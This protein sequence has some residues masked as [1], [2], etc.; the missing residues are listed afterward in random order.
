[1]SAKEL[2]N[3]TTV[4]TLVDQRK[5]HAKGISNGSCPL[6]STSI[7]TD[8]DSLPIVGNVVLDVLAQKMAA[9]K[10]VNGNVE[11]ALV[12]GVV[13]VHGDDMVSTSTG[14]QVRD[15]VGVSIVGGQAEQ[16]VNVPSVPAWA[17]HCL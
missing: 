9:V 4:L 5:R 17:T 3:T 2:Q 11:E 8:N 10:V 14:Q 13:Q 16:F 7:R 6:S 12:L 1:M 15:Y